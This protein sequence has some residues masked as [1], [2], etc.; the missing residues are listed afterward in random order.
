[1]LMELLQT[2]DD[3][4]DVSSAAETHNASVCAESAREPRRSKPSKVAVADRPSK[5]LAASDKLN[6][7]SFFSGALGMDIGLQKAGLNVVLA[8]KIDRMCR[9]TIVMNDDKVGLI[10]DISRY[11]P[12]Q[13][14]EWSGLKPNEVDVIVGGPPC[15]AFSTAGRRKGFE[16]DRG[17]VFLDFVDVILALRP[18]YAV[19]ENVRGLLSA[20]LKHRPHAERTSDKPP[21]Q[22][23]LP[24]GA[25]HHI[26]DVLE[27]GGYRVTFN[28][29]NS[30]NYGVPQV[31]ERLVLLCHRDGDALPY[32]MPKHSNDDQ[33]DLPA[34]RTV[35]QAIG[36]LGP[37]NDHINFPEARLK[38]YRMLK[39]GQYWRHLPERLQKEALGASYFSGGGKTGFLR[40]LAWD[41]PSCTLVT[42]PAMPATDICHPVENRPL[43]VGEYKRIQ[44]FPDDWQLAGSLVDQYKQIGNAVPVG[45]GAAIGRVLVK[46]ASGETNHPPE[47]FPFSRYRNTADT[48]FRQP[49]KARAQLSLFETDR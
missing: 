3:N 7:L 12:D 1:M 42:H 26:I 19:I 10:G 37:Q 44:Q 24:G 14:L 27:A 8:C 11:S 30:A 15:Q 2:T 28:L 49:A 38:Y 40:R 20:P 33:Y 36:D 22:E 5:K 41:K 39:E 9:Q 4:S 16:D 21:T 35:R 34:W 23:E 17:N 47:G 43:S 32:L 31:R 45:L 46:H 25:L 48:N 18:R 29:Y 6:T 13:I